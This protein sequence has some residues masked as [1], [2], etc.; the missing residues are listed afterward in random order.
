MNGKWLAPVAFLALAA[1]PFTACGGDDEEAGDTS[2]NG[3]ASATVTLTARDFSF[4][5]TELTGDPGQLLTVKVQNN[6]AV[7]HTFTVNDLGIDEEIAAGEE[8]DI[9][10]TSAGAFEFY[11]RYHQSKMSGTIT[12]GEGGGASTTDS[13]GGSGYGY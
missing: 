2:G 1:L 3:A 11:C 4:E 10:V 7:E 13:G 6:G 5:P 9:E 12:I 8:K